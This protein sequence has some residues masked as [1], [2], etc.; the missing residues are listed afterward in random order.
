M[1]HDNDK[2][3]C[4]DTAPEAEQAQ[5][6][7]AAQPAA[8]ETPA[9]S[10]EAQ[11]A[12]EEAKKAEKKQP[13][14][15]KKEKVSLKKAMSSEKFKHGSMA[16]ALTAVFIA[17]VVLVNVLVGI[18]GE[19]FP[20]INYDMSQNS[21]NS[22]S[23]A[24]IEVV[25]SVDEPTE[26]LIMM[27]ESSAL[28]SSN[29][30]KV[31][32]ITAKMAER[33]SNITVQ[34]KDPDKEPGLLSEY[35]GLASGYVLVRTD[36]RFR[37]VTSSDLF[38]AKMDQ[39]TYQTVYYTDINGALASAI[40][41][42]N[43]DEMP[44]VAFDTGHS[45]R[46]DVSAYKDLL[47]DNNFEPVDFNLLTD[48]IPEETQIVVLGVPSTDLDESEI[49]KLNTFLNDTSTSLDRSVFV[50]SYVA[51][52]EL[53]TLNSYLGEWGLS[54]TQTEVIEGDSTSYVQSP[55]MLLANV[56]EE[57]DLDGASSYGYILCPQ[58]NAVDILW[59]SRNS[60]ST[61]SLLTSSSSAHLYDV[62]TQTENTDV[63]GTYNL[64]A[65][66]V[67][68]IKGSDGS[69][70]NATVAVIGSPFLFT[71]TF[72]N[73]STYGNSQYLTDLSRYVTGT[74]SSANAV[75]STPQEMVTY[76]IAMSGAQIMY[77]ALLVFAGLIPLAFLI[78]GIVV[79]FR[80]R[81]L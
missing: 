6:N 22:L 7:E 34:Y 17:A 36:K 81:H 44:V 8:E 28:S 62:E 75:Y 52:G 16:T 43:A 5:E 29:Y 58:T 13:A 60:V 4:Q 24:A 51:Q 18:L 76:D 47:S 61:Y 20:S 11:A 53:P 10:P 66:G 46:L 33:N 2:N 71:E 14:K 64:A 73:S 67:K 38:P 70:F 30:Q 12:A 40:S 3:K 50:V 69:Y 23:E 65:A 80:R 9:V 54:I 48:E 21:E 74:T 57:P 31:D 49:E 19:R 56:S 55:D 1:N 26:I 39:S 79:F 45:E 25:D 32:S 27:D 63:T 77:I 42:V 72:L 15:K 35:E 68:M 41:A 78:T 59:E 37:V